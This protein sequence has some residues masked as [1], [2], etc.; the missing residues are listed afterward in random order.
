MKSYGLL[1]LFCIAVWRVG[2]YVA[3][4][5]ARF[6]GEL[7]NDKSSRSVVKVDGCAVE[8]GGQ[9]IGGLGRGVYCG[10]KVWSDEFKKSAS[11]KVQEVLPSP[12]S[13]L[14]MG[15]VLGEDQFNLVPTYNDILKK[16][17][18]IHVVVVSGYNISLVFTLLMRIL[19][20]QYKLKNLLFGLFSTLI[21]AGISGF[22]IPAVRAWIMGSIA[23]IFKFY[24]RPSHGIKVLLFSGIVLV[25]LAPSQLFSVSFMLSFLAT[26]GVMVVPQALTGLLSSLGVKKLPGVLEDFTTSLSAQLMVNPVLSYYFGSISAVSLISNPLVLWVV[27]IC[28]ILGGLLVGVSFIFPL[29]AKLLALVLFPFLDFFVSLSELFANFR[30]ASVNLR[31]SAPAVFGYYFLLLAFIKFFTAKANK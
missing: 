9:G 28:T 1:I 25:C 10:F 24:G 17:G 3:W 21:Y 27:P 30:S 22:G 4:D 15:M 29:L 13:E 14:V 6:L 8:T 26:L 16:V 23:V 2:G 31:F 12:H 11:Y 20:S 5:G 7:S 19:G 18:L